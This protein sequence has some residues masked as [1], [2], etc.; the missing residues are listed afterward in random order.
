MSSRGSELAVELQ[1]QAELGGKLPRFV[2]RRHCRRANSWLNNKKRWQIYVSGEDKTCRGWAWSQIT[3]LRESLAL[4]KSF[5]NC[6]VIP[7]SETTNDHSYSTGS[8]P[9]L[10]L[11][12]SPHLHRPCPPSKAKSLP[13]NP[14]PLLLFSFV[15]T[16]GK[17]DIW[18]APLSESGLNNSV[19]NEM[20][21]FF[22]ALVSSTSSLFFARR[23]IVSKTSQVGQ[24]Y[25][26]LRLHYNVHM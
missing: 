26:L 19:Q 15:L 1:D 23:D 24:Y 11:R 8:I 4:Y 25:D 2:A 13:A 14:P 16:G 21:T 10:N 22:C 5:N 3:R 20:T 12:L 17:S 9:Q 18:E 6:L 7:L